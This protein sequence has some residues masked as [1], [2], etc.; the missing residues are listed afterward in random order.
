MSATGRIALVVNLVIACLVGPVGVV[1]LD[2][3]PAAKWWR[4]LP[5]TRG[6]S[7]TLRRMA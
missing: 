3:A 2:Q 1:P 7:P 6:R 5:L 4:A